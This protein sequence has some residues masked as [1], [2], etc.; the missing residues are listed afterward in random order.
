MTNA[1][2]RPAT[3][4]DLPAITRLVKGLAIYEKLEHRFTATEADFERLLFG[5]SPA[6]EAILAGDPPVGIALFYRIVNTFQ[7]QTGLF[8]EDLFVEPTHRGTGLGK[9]LLRELAIIAKARGADW[10]EWR[11]LD[12]NAPSIAFYE[13]LGARKVDDW[14]TRRLSGSALTALA[15]GETAHG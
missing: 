13:S 8:L 7:C 15:R 6:A 2:I 4:A 3:P 12:W 11:V 9:A 10:L 1:I 14:H 5:P